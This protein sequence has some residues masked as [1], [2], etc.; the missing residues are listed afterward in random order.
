[1]DG[2]PPMSTTHPKAPSVDA[3]PTPP[4]RISPPYNKGDGVSVANII[5][6]SHKR[7]ERRRAMSP[8]PHPQ[9]SINRIKL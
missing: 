5:L 6:N 1:M 4:L 3:Y 2:C 8:D 7:S 9:P